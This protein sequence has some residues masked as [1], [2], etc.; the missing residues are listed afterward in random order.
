M[1]TFFLLIT[2]RT[3]C[4]VIKISKK[5]QQQQTYSLSLFNILNTTWESRER[6]RP[7]KSDEH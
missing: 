4:K 3:L 5:K 2:V 6:E 1:Q 7:L